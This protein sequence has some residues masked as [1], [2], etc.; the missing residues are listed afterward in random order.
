MDQNEQAMTEAT[1]LPEEIKIIFNLNIDEEGNIN[2]ENTQLPINAY[3]ISTYRD[4]SNIKENKNAWLDVPVEL[5][6]KEFNYQIQTMEQD[7]VGQ[8]RIS[9]NTS[10][11]RFLQ[12]KEQIAN[13][14]RF[15]YSQSFSDKM[16][17]EIRICH[18]F[19]TI[20]LEIN[21]RRRTIIYDKSDNTILY[22]VVANS[23]LEALINSSYI[24]D[25]YFEHTINNNT[26]VYVI[27]KYQ[28][29]NSV[30]KA[31]LGD[32]LILCSNRLLNTI[33]KLVQLIDKLFYN[34][35]IRLTVNQ[36]DNIIYTNMFLSMHIGHI[37][38]N[39]IGEFLDNS[40]GEYK[41]ESAVDSIIEQLESSTEASTTM[42][43][44]TI[45]GLGQE[46][47]ISE[48]KS[49]NNHKLGNGEYDSSIHLIQYRRRKSNHDYVSSLDIE[50]DKEED[51]LNIILN[52]SKE[53]SKKE[54]E[55]GRRIIALM[56]YGYIAKQ[57]YYN[58]NL[59]RE[60][61]NLQDTKNKPTKAT[62]SKKQSL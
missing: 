22:I 24:E 58:D 1:D 25:L 13:I 33:Y 59:K 21:D 9:L 40:D 29:Q 19:T 55:I 27:D 8:L 60:A 38:L 26:T 39:Y 23:V 28:Y 14:K 10:Y 57:K 7:K 37:I 42:E 56:P 61:G 44:H 4:I 35:K 32:K 30:R 54:I 41:F 2:T 49:T 5:I 6:F 46:D 3:M 53:A 31:L 12:K 45:W 15:E 16:Y 50:P 48:I 43:L 17:L 11:E 47:Y 62:W 18:T 34:R 36:Q 51:I 20:Q 52:F